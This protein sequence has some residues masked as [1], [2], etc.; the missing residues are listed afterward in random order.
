MSAT[1]NFVRQELLEIAGALERI[2]TPRARKRSAAILIRNATLEK[3]HCKF[4]GLGPRLGVELHQSLDPTTWICAF[5]AWY[6]T[7]GRQVLKR[8]HDWA[9]LKDFAP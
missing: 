5:C 7:R 6:I 4:C 2:F 3:P 1:T 9:R 8:E